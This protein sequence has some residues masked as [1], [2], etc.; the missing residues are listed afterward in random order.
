MKLLIVGSDK[1]YAIENFYVRYIR[2]AGWNVKCYAASSVFFDY[3]HKGGILNKLLFKSGLSPIIRDINKEFL[4]EVESFNPDIIWIFKGMQITADSLKR[5]KEKGILIVNFNPD[6]PF[7]FT[8]TGSGNKNITD[9]LHL[10]DLHFTYNLEIKKE[11]ESRLK[12]NAVFLPFAFDVSQEIFDQCSLQNE[13]VKACFLGNP[14]KQRAAILKEI[15]S[16]GVKIDVYGNNWSDF[17]EDEN[18]TSHD[19]VYAAELWKVLRRYR[20][21]INL[22][23]IHNED[24]HNMRTFEIAGI[25]GIQVAPY[26]S[27]HALFFEDGKEIFL[28]KNVRDCAGIIKKLLSISETEANEIRNASRSAALSRKNTYRD[29]SLM[30]IKTLNKLMQKTVV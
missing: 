11:L 9:S 25:G 18:I 6:N 8:G 30:V 4:N 21:Q 20:A 24:S 7:I 15:A 13:V 26:T 5:V 10:Y 28:Y 2:E 19:P 3:Y 29:R 1:V 23:R 22:M 17:L 12:V 16:E 14:D 27:E